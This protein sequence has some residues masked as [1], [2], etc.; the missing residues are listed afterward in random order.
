VSVPGSHPHRF[1]YFS[2]HQGEPGYS[3]KKFFAA[4]LPELAREEKHKGFATAEVRE[5]T[6]QPPGTAGGF[7][8]A[9]A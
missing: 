2:C 4:T 3:A 5:G 6:P 8:R 7:G 1:I 9:T